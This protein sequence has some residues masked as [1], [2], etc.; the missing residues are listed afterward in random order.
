[1]TELAITCS[2]SASEA[3][4]RLLG[5]TGLM[6]KPLCRARFAPCTRCSLRYCTAQCSSAGTERLTCIA[7]S[8]CTVQDNAATLLLQIQ[9][10]K[11]QVLHRCCPYCQGRIKHACLHLPCQLASMPETAD[12]QT[13]RRGTLPASWSMSGLDMLDTHLLTSPRGRRHQPAHKSAS[14]LDDCGMTHSQP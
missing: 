4:Y 7:E 5:S 3:L 1:M 10:S 6:S 8:G 13:G 9:E 12:K 11:T 14:V 2:S